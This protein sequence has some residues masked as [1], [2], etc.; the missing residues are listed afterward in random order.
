MS[1]PIEEL[2]KTCE[3]IGKECHELV[4]KRQSK[5]I[6]DM[7]FVNEYFQLLEKMDTGEKREEV[8]NNLEEYAKQN[9]KKD[10]SKWLK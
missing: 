5:Q 8:I 3:I 4:E 7:R 2:A 9:L 10:T 1:N 6:G